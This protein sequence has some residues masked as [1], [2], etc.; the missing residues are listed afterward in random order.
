MAL[1]V[2]ELQPN[3]I[4]QVDPH[5]G[6]TQVLE[7]ERKCSVRRVVSDCRAVADED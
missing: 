1:V 6:S 5:P 2:D 4:S 3:L 7:S